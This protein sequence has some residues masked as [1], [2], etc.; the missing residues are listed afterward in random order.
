MFQVDLN[1][2]VFKFL[3]SLDRKL[4]ERCYT[5]LK[6]L[7]EDLFQ[8]RAKCDIKK[9]SGKGGEY[10]LRVGSIRFEYTLYKEKELVLVKKAF[11]R[12]KGYR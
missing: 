2:Q 9:M 3:D 4:Y 12:E 8:K 10:R 6:M 7:E 1:P 11:W 5:S